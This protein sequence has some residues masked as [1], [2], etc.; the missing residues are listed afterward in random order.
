MRVSFL[1]D[2]LGTL[3]GT[4]ASICQSAEVLRKAGTT[5]AVVVYPREDPPHPHWL[6]VLRTAGVDLCVLDTSDE[7]RAAEQAWRWLARWRVDLVHA[8]P[9]GRFMLSC[10]AAD[11]RLDRPVVATET[12]EGSARCTWYDETTFAEMAALDAIVA[13]CRRVA[14]NV[15]THFGFA[16]RI[17]V[18]PHLLR[19]PEDRIRPL[20]R[21]DLSRLHRL[22]SVTRLRHEKGIPFLLAAVALPTTPAHCQLSIYG[23]TC[24]LDSTQTVVHALSLGSRVTIEGPFAGEAEMERI[25]ATHPIVLLSSLFEGLPL[26]LLNAIGRGRIGIATDVGGVRDILGE[27]LAGTVVPVA[28]PTAMS[29]AIRDFVR[30]PGRA[31]RCSVAAVEIFR[32]RFHVSKT[33]ARTLRFYGDVAG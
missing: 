6:S 4:E 30:D 32:D 1:T 33:L 14:D 2:Y 19:V 5:I 3:S 27:D 11:G 18:I 15:R 12:S 21:E 10:L 20:N 29:L 28:D 24:E 26:A 7:G 16:G 8:I 23:E 17:E 13:P 9:M 25:Y 22:G 31:M